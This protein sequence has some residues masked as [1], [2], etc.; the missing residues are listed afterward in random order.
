MS[1]LSD[2]CYIDSVTSQAI[3]EEPPVVNG[4]NIDRISLNSSRSRQR[5]DSHGS[6]RSSSEE[7]SPQHQRKNQPEKKEYKTTP[8]RRRTDLASKPKRGEDKIVVDVNSVLDE[9]LAG[10]NDLKAD[11]E[12]EESDDEA[13]DEP[14]G[15]GKSKLSGKDRS[16]SPSKYSKLD[17]SSKSVDNHVRDSSYKTASRK[18]EVET[19]SYK[20]STDDF[21]PRSAVKSPELVVTKHDERRSE[22][23][24]RFRSGKAEVIENNKPAPV[25]QQEEPSYRMRV[26]S[27]AFLKDAHPRK[28]LSIKRDDPIEE[29]TGKSKDLA[30]DSKRKGRPG[31]MQSEEGLQ[32]SGSWTRRKQMSGDKALGMFYHNRRSQ[33]IDGELLEEAEK[34]LQER[35]SST[36]ASNPLSPP[37]HTVTSP[38]LR[39]RDS[40][41]FSPMPSPLVSK[42]GFDEL[43]T[44]KRRSDVKSPSPSVGA[45]AS[46]AGNEQEDLEVCTCVHA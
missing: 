38:T 9:L 22:P 43:H 31:S 2:L 37:A 27:N 40:R 6:K 21:K 20:S 19:K 29:D 12:G 25:E 18:P 46:A 15:Y 1:L 7:S 4:V 34:R 28:G 17:T 42:S 45:P 41:S 13:E 35:R 14:K 32:R 26:R 33:I 24:H 36:E 8:T 5:R 23:T 39:P 44:D 11:L 3:K 16:K 10:M 30:K